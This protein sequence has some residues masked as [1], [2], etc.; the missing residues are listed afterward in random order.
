MGKEVPTTLESV[1][2]ELEPP[3]WP[4]K[5]L[6][7][8]YLDPRD[9]R[10]AVARDPAGWA[11]LRARV[12][13]RDG[14][15]VY[16]GRRQSTDR[17]ARLEVN[18]LN[19]YRDNRLE[20]LETVCVLCHRVLHGGRSSAIYG[21]LLLFRQAACDQNTLIRVCWWLRER[22]HLPDRP[23]MEI[24][25]LKDQAPFRMDRAY[26]ATLYGY[27]VERFWLLERRDTASG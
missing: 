13:A 25:G 1:L 23:L 6:R 24:L 5:P 11:S 9:W 27:V 16:C 21:S 20:A 4:L 7:P 12:I 15:C 18:H 19:G 8:S 26:L 14:G 3:P 10:P 17:R 2:A 22:Q